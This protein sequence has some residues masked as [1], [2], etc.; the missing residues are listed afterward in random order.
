VYSRE[1]LDHF[2]HPR[3]AGFVQGADASVQVENPVCGDVLKLSARVCDGRI[4]EIRFQAK[5]CVPAMACGS[6]V[7][8]LATSKVVGEAARIGANDIVKHVCGLPPASSHAAQLAAEALAQL[9]H[10]LQPLLGSK[11]K[12]QDH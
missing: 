2:E 10:K 5:G 8:E 1:L 4:A 6:A 11:S 7:A 3:S 12:L 9:L